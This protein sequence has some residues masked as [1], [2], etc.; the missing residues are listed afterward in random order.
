MLLNGGLDRDANT[1]VVPPLELD[2]TISPHSII[3]QSVSVDPGFS[4]E[5]YGLGWNMYSI[6]GHDVSKSLSLSFT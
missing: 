4:A 5:L 1:T 6:L 2:V 3:N